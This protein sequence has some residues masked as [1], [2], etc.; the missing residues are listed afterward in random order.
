MSQSQ[1]DPEEQGSCFPVDTTGDSN[2]TKVLVLTQGEAYLTK[3][4][5]DTPT[6]TGWSWNFDRGY[7]WGVGL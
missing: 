7:Q 2:R 5:Q 4:N 3:G 6:G 1:T